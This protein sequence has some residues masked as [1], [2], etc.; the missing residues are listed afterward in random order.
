MNTETYQLST[1][2]PTWEEFADR[3]P[4]YKLYAKKGGERIFKVLL[5]PEAFVFSKVA[6]SMG[7]PAVA[8]VAERVMLE[9][10]HQGKILSAFDKQFV[11]AVVCV[12]MEAN[13]FEKTGKKKAI[14]HQAFSKGEVYQTRY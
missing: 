13:G 10:Q 6:T 11:G 3:F 9:A 12:L 5:T 14:P 4:Q 8:G 7:L 1:C 2:I